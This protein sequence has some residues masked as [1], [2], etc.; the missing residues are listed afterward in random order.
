MNQQPRNSFEQE[1]TKPRRGFIAEFWDFTR[2][3][4]KWWLTPLIVVLLLAGLLVVLSGS[5]LA[6]FIYT[7][8]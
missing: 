1:A 4:K 5:G 7:L 6:P 2:N 8:F 3:N